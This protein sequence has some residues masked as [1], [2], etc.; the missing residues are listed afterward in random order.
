MFEKN[1]VTDWVIR[2]L[3]LC[4][5]VAEAV[6]IVCLFG[7]KT[8]G[9]GSRLF[10]VAAVLCVLLMLG[11]SVFVGKRYQEAERRASS[12][13]RT[14]KLLL[15]AFVCLVLLQE[16][17]FFMN[18]S[19]YLDGDMMTETVVSFLQTDR[20]Y[21]VNPLTGEAY[22]MGLPTRI[23][24]LGLPSLYTFLCKA[25]GCSP[26]YFVWYI[27]PGAVCLFTYCGFACL[28]YGLFPKERKRRLLFL[29]L[30]GLLFFCGNYR[31]GMDGFGLLYCGWR[32]VT[33]RNLI[34]LPYTLSLCLRKR[35]L[36]T[37]LCVLAEACITWTLYGLGMCA[38]LT[39]LCFAADRAR[40][41]FER[42]GKEC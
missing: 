15:A 33:I 26:D 40:T 10:L 9:F 16:L 7:G 35:Y 32:A 5:G 25:F 19:R 22:S 12:F 30:V 1:H 39:V 20:I 34:L 3:I 4:I 24:V 28:A 41:Y 31:F 29:I 38:A 6:H 27:V 8:I 21:Q 18:D 13:D 23:K 42:R 36:E 17:F 11:F 14:E 37:V 2:G